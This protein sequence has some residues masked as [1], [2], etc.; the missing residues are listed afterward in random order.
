MAVTVRRRADGYRFGRRALGGQRVREQPN[1]QQQDE[2]IRPKSLWQR[3]L[4]EWLTEAAAKGPRA[5]GDG[6][7]KSAKG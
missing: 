3:L 6:K 5:G 2:P 7:A 1:M 4:A